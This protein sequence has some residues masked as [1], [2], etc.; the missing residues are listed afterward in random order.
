MDDGNEQTAL[1]VDRN[2]QVL[3]VVVRDGSSFLVHR[4]VDNGEL[5]QRFQCCASKERQEG[6]LDTFASKEIILGPIPQ[7]SNARDVNFDNAGQLGCGL[8]GLDHALSDDLAQTRHLFSA[9]TQ[10]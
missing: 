9:A 2:T 4:R 10:R 8:Q 7:S 1:G 3:A 5:L 6:E